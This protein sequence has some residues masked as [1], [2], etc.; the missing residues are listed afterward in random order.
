MLSL[1]VVI[2]V[3]VRCL[4]VMLFLPFDVLDKVFN[5]K[6]AVG[7]AR[8]A[9]SA[10]KPAMLL[11]LIGLCVKVFTSPGLVIGVA[12]RFAACVLAGY[13]IVTALLWKQFWRLRGFRHSGARRGGE[14]FCNFLKNFS[15]AGGFLR[16][17]F[18]TGAKT[19]GDF[20][21]PRYASSHPYALS[22]EHAGP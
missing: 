2:A 20:L 1:S 9:V 6:G 3:A 4:L 13:C 14:L 16:I 8:E 19:V 7:E 15:L 17:T 12:D 11:I 10:S 22:Q 21:A 5:I 18:G